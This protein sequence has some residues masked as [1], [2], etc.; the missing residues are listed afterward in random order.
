MR[1]LVWLIGA[2]VLLV[3]AAATQITKEVKW[4]AADFIIFGSMLAAACLAFEATAAL[5]ENRRYLIAGGLAIL[6]AFFV[7]WVEL[8]VGIASPG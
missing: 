7:V 3:P 8:A 1:H 5:T 4:D 2:V 6:A